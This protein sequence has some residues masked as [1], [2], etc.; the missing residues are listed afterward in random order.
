SSAEG[1]ASEGVRIL[2]MLCSHLCFGAE[3]ADI[4]SLTDTAKALLSPAFTQQLKEQLE[5]GLSFPAARQAALEKM[6]CNGNCLTRPNDILATEYCKAILSQKSALTP[7]VIQRQGSYHDTA[8]DSENP[9]ATAV[10][11]LMLHSGAWLDYVPEAAR[12]CFRNTAVHTVQAGERAMLAK[13]R[14]MTDAEF[15]AL[16]YSSEGLWRKLMKACRQ[17]AT[18]EDILTSVKSK[19]YTRTRLDRMV[20]CAFLGLTARDLAAPVPYV[21]V[22]ALNDRGRQI[23][24]E[25]RKAGNFPNIG[26]VLEDPYQA[27]ETRCG[28]LYGLF[29][30]TPGA[31]NAE[32]GLRIYYHKQETNT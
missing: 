15:E 1:F 25:A 11:E 12:D 4:Q 32:H 27:I 10:R 22:L 16:P 5:T 6:G 17:E 9:S 23:L 14:T 8:P 20:M 18:L 28:R 2:S 3:T 13:L 30:E 26:E 24:K 7:I 19:R 31:P 21:R 29:A